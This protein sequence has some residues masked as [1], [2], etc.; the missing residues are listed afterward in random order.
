M[1]ASALCKEVDVI[2]AESFDR[3]SRDQEDTAGLFKRLTFAGTSIVTLA[4]PASHG[5]KGRSERCEARRGSELKDRMADLQNR[6]DALPNQLE[7]ADELP[8][9]LHP[10]IS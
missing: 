7:V 6:K 4:E 3:F 5:A 1:M 8:P 10:S 9:L 2:L